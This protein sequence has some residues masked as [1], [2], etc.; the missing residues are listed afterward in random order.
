MILADSN[1]M[2]DYFRSRDSELAKQID[3]MPIALCGTVRAELL[4]G[5]RSNEEIDDFLAAFKTFENLINDDYDWEGTGF[6][7]QTLRTNGIQVPL[8]DALIAFTAIKYDIPLWTR[9]NHF[10]FIQGFY[11]ELKLYEPPQAPAT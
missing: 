9:D 3:S 10:K 2:I 7:L 8:A 4:H 1:V 5:A 11:P 6:L